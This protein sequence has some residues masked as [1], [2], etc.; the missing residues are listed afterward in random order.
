MLTCLRCDGSGPPEHSLQIQSVRSVARYARSLINCHFRI[1]SASVHHLGLSS[2]MG[3]LARCYKVATYRF[4]RPLIDGRVFVW[5]E[6][7]GKC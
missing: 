1:A 3:R 2:A 4:Q 5:L 6:Q 7:M